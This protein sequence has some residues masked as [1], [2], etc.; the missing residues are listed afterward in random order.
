MHDNPTIS[1]DHKAYLFAGE[2]DARRREDLD[3]LIESL[4]LPEF[5][6]FDLSVVDGETTSAQEILSMV[7]SVPFASK[8]KVV[9]VESVD[10]LPPAD[11]LRIAEFIP[12]LGDKSCLIM[13]LSEKSAPSKSRTSPKN[14]EEG[15]KEEVTRHGLQPK[16]RNA[17]KRYGALIEYQ[18]LK[19][20][21]LRS[22]VM[23]E[24]RRHGKQIQVMA[25]EMLAQSTDGN[26]SIIQREIEK[27][28]LFVGDKK[29]ISTA[30][31]E[32]ITPRTAED[33][34][35]Q[36]MD[37]VGNKR[38]E[39]AVNL[40]SETLAASTKPEEDVLRII[41]ML[42]RHFRMLYQAIFLRE[43]G[44][45]DLQSIPEDVQEVLP[46]EHNLLGVHDFAK[47]RFLAQS[48]LFTLVEVRRC[49]RHVL[50]CEVAVKGIE[51]DSGSRRIH[52]EMLIMKL[53]KRI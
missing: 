46:K 19:S 22:V 17:T 53:C 42:A 43:Q 48:R 33:R 23:Q 21:D 34:I 35:F 27:L 6:T 29:I 30:D 50:E 16:L 13:L 39:Q 32:A 24:A 47:K 4:V 36:L 11:Q 41:S 49:L 44:I 14:S 45:R 2:S 25:A 10:L 18:K 31:V 12:K 37:A 52:L 5:A 20:E 8:K 1:L 15:E 28:V 26:V 3:H 9:V 7:T 38:A 40:L 51:G